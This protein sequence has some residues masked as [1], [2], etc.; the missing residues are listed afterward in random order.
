M[1]KFTLISD[2][3]ISY[4]FLKIAK[5]SLKNR[6]THISLFYMHFVFTYR[7][8]LIVIKSFYYNF[9]MSYLTSPPPPSFP[10]SIFKHCDSLLI[11]N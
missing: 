11:K 9:K 2:Y 8:F 5:I 1:E 6:L 4:L 3:L 7:H 10:P